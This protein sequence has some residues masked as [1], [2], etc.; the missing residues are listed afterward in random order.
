LKINSVPVVLFK[1][2]IMKGG[3]FEL[4]RFGFG[5]ELQIDRERKIESIDCGS[6]LIFD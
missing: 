4:S 1:N 5:D 6:I 2:L 3:P